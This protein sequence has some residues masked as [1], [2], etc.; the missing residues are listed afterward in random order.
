V[1]YAARGARHAARARAADVA[2]AR[3]RRRG[4]GV[5]VCAVMQKKMPR[6]VDEYM[7]AASRRVDDVRVPRCRAITFLTRGDDDD[8]RLRS[9]RRAQDVMQ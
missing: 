8:A 4:Y 1:L 5:I 2:A 6:R 3:L 7:S 9:G